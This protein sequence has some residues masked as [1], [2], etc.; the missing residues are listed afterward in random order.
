MILNAEAIKKVYFNTG[1]NGYHGCTKCYSEGTFAAGSMRWPPNSEKMES[2]KFLSSGR[3]CL[4]AVIRTLKPAYF[5]LKA[6]SHQSF[7]QTRQRW[8]GYIC[9]RSV[10]PVIFEETFSKGIRVVEAYQQ[11]QQKL[12]D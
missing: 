10:L 6:L 4:L 5:F 3:T 9:S 12:I 11:L 2:E 1:F 7:P 8:N